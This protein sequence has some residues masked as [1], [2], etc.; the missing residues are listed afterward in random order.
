MRWWKKIKSFQKCPKIHAT[1]TSKQI[2]TSSK[3]R[4]NFNLPPP[5][6]PDHLYITYKYSFHVKKRK[7][8]KEIYILDNT[9]VSRIHP[10]RRM[11]NE[12]F[13]A[14]TGPGPCTK[15]LNV[16]VSPRRGGKRV[17]LRA[18]LVSSGTEIPAR[19][20]R[21]G[22]A[23]IGRKKGRVKEACKR[24][25]RDPSGAAVVGEPCDAH[26]PGCG[27]YPFFAA[28]YH[29]DSRDGDSRRAYLE[30]CM[31]RS[32]GPLLL[33]SLARE[34]VEGQ[35]GA[36]PVG[37]TDIKICGRTGREVTRFFIAV[38]VQRE[39]RTQWVVL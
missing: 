15:C 35:T 14:H 21:G 12:K 10:S 1:V 11:A 3:S 22:G 29:A 19:W 25:Q 8:R 27:V 20:A 2:F 30:P 16:G 38:Q 5:P 4:L 36:G 33:L 39:G 9:T 6:P 7:K 24:E 17:F 28:R 31:Q 13:K 32:V 34:R 23:C 26:D 18:D 37:S